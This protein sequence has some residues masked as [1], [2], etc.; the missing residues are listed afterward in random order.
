MILI[1]SMKENLSNENIA[2]FLFFSSILLGY[3]VVFWS[4]SPETA[5]FLNFFVGL[6][7]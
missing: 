4:R 3:F 7:F 1:Y 2:Y 5:N 6:K